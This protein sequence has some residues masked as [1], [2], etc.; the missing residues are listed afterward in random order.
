MPDNNGTARLDRIESVLELLIAD[1][2]QFREEHKQLLTA[3]IV[4]TDRLDRF[5]Q[6]STEFQKRIEEAQRRTEEAQRRT[7]EKL[8]E[9]A[10]K[11]NGLIG[12]VQGMQPPPKS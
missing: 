3:Q 7:D 1:H 12:Y 5:I 9:L 4:L 11:L 2:V 6:A 8:A 10:D